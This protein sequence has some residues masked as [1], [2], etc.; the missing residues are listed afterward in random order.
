MYSITNNASL[1]VTNNLN[2]KNNFLVFSELVDSSISFE[3]PILVSTV[4]E[5][6]LWFG[7]FFNSYFYLKNLLLASDDI[8]LLLYKPDEL[9]YFYPKEGVNTF[10][11]KEENLFL[12]KQDLPTIGEKNVYYYVNSEDDY[13][14][15]TDQGWLFREDYRNKYGYNVSKNNRDTLMITTKANKFFTHYNPMFNYVTGLPI[16]KKLTVSPS[17]YNLNNVNRTN[18][19]RNIDTSELDSGQQTLSFEIKIMGFGNLMIDDDFFLLIPITYGNSTGIKNSSNIKESDL[20]KYNLFYVSEKGKEEAL[21]F[22]KDKIDLNKVKTKH[23]DSLGNEKENKIATIDDITNIFYKSGYFI[24][25]EGAEF[26]AY[27]TFPVKSFYLT[28]KPNLISLTVS[29][30]FNQQ[31]LSNLA[32]NTN[33]VFFYSKTI[34]KTFDETD[35]DSITITITSLNIEK[36]LYKVIIKKYNYEEVYEG[37]A[38]STNDYE[39]LDY[40]ISTNSKLVYCRFLDTTSGIR[41]GVYTMKGSYALS[42]L[43]ISAKNHQSGLDSMLAYAKEKEIYP[44]YVL[45]PDIRR[46]VGNASGFRPFY[47]LLKFYAEDLNTQFLILNKFCS[48]CYQDI[49]NSSSYNG[50]FSN[51]MVSNVSTIYKLDLDTNISDDD[52]KDQSYIYVTF[53]NPICYEVVE[54]VDRIEYAKAG[55]DYVFNNIDEDNRLIYFYQDCYIDGVF[56]VPIYYLYIQGLL[57]N[58][59]SYSSNAITIDPV[60]NNDPYQENKLEKEL[61]KYKSNYMICNNHIYYF[62]KMQDGSKYNTTGWMRFILGKIYRELQKNKGELIGEKFKDKIETSIKNTLN[63]IETRFSIIKYLTIDKINY[64]DLHNSLALSINVGVKEMV[65]DDLTIDFILNYNNN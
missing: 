15:Y 16:Y 33:S 44:D 20:G 11:K 30:S 37:P 10:S 48:E 19:L 55:N 60:A 3:T 9:I 63:S 26:T 13:Y 14:I 31:I 4:E 45:M 52:Y 65:G 53:R 23:V 47:N 35:E 7:R 62:K 61:Q 22:C 42:D 54:D 18:S 51:K 6:E 25:G 34:G 50:I 1:A 38:T 56:K 49:S 21:A 5:L 46:Y 32:T 29:D 57:H 24:S 64:D 27:T 12:T 59:Y 28:N 58:V 36:K 41:E 39:R 40:I 2:T 43:M 17:F 8:S